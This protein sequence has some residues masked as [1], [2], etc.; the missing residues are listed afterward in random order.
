MRSGE[1]HESL[2]ADPRNPYGFAKDALRRELEFLAADLGFK[3][4]WARL[5]YMYGE[6]Q[7]PSSLYSQFMAAG[8]AGAAEFPMSGGEQLRDL[9]HVA[10]VA[11]RLPR[12]AR[13][14]A[15]ARLVDGS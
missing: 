15:G 11:E 14:G 1:L 13:A 9:L 5:F 3:L 6:G 2:P 7:A 10:D 4:G 8:S 12:L